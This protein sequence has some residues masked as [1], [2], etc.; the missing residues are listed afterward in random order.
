MV[1][2]IYTARVCMHDVGG[3]GEDVL[4]IMHGRSRLRRG[5]TQCHY[6]RGVLNECH[7][8]S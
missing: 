6:S 8:W 4:D 7:I 5:C 1:A 2:Y 3:E